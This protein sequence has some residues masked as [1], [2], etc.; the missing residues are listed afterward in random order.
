MKLRLDIG[1]LLD[2]I[3]GSRPLFFNNGVTTV[4][5]ITAGAV[6]DSIDMFTMREQTL[7]QR[8]P[9]I[10]KSKFFRQSRLLNIENKIYST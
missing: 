6:E 7:S 1:R 9:V 5:F 8:S 3:S 2:S 4:Y 10:D